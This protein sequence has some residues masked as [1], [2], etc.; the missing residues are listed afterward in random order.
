MWTSHPWLLWSYLN[1][2]TGSVNAQEIQDLDDA[3]RAGD[4]IWHANPMNMQFES[5]EPTHM[6]E[7]LDLTTRLRKRY[8][9]TANATGTVAA[10]NKDEPGLTLGMLKMFAQKGIKFMHVGVNDFSTVPAVP[11]TSAHFHGYCNTFAWVRT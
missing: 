3:I 7:Q 11:S 6:A 4:I 5:A 9:F 8:N 2:E 10:S 1:N